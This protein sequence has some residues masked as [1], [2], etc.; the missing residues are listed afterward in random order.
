MKVLVT[1]AS[2]FVGAHVTRALLG[3]GAEVR[4]LVR[5]A[6]AGAS[7]RR[8]RAAARPPSAARPDNLAGLPVER[9]PGDL[10][11]PGSLRRAVEG[12]DV[13]YHVA[14][15][16]RL[17]TRDPEAMYAANVD[18]TDSL[19]ASA[20]EAGVGKVVYTSSVGA[21]GKTSDGTPADERT[22]VELGDMVGHYKRSKFLAERVAERWVER[23]LPV[24]VVNPSTPVGELDVKPTPTGQM[25][26]DFL[27]RRFPA[28]VDTGLNLVDVRDVAEGHLLAAERGRPGERYILGHC[29]MSLLE[30][31]QTLSRLTGLPAPR[32]RVPHWLPLA[33]AYVGGGVSRLTGATPRVTPEAVR[34]SRHRMFFDSGK[35]V[36]ELGLP[37]SPVEEALARA[38]GWF[39]D[40][41]YAPGRAA[42]VERT[43]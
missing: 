1:G 21:L 17:F 33:A 29:N 22:P 14:A 25:I 3:R 2:G 27:W 20:A 5:P 15:D 23:G 11:E 12:C 9:F 16:Y 39:T 32:L 4:C 26:V 19:L 24:V 42:R 43:A 35:A 31:L 34:M 41:G 18:G 36:R 10:C 8:P 40:H 6:R 38:V 28:Y 7:A 30:I 37:Q 13:V